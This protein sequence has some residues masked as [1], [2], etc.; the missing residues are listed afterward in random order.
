MS[1]TQIIDRI[2]QLETKLRH[3]TRFD[4]W[5]LWTWEEDRELN[6]LKAKLLEFEIK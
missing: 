4:L 6:E 1:K 2:H 5:N 3:V